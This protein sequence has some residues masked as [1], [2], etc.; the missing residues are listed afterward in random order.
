MHQIYLRKWSNTKGL[1]ELIATDEALLL[2]ILQQLLALPE[3]NNEAYQRVIQRFARKSG[4]YFAKSE[5]YDGYK[6]LVAAGKLAEHKA[7]AQI[8]QRK[9][10]RTHSGVAPVTVLTKPFPCPGECIFC[11]TFDSMP[12]SYVPDEP[13][14]LRALQNDFDPYRQVMSRLRSLQSIG[15]Q[16]AK[17]E[18]LILGG[19]WSSYHRSYQ[20]WFVQRCL[21]AMNGNVG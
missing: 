18:L 21:D 12:K 14:S 20:T 10:V 2:D 15:H 9:P 11:P 1:N 8:L 17:V 5:L 13:G 4:R 6:Q 7:L 16:A 19:T 3:L